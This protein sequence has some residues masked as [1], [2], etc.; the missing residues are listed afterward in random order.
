MP[1]FKKLQ[2][3]HIAAINIFL[4]CSIYQGDTDKYKVWDPGGLMPVNITM[5]Q[6]FIALH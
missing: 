6:T 3:A 5:L 2:S 1:A 4:N